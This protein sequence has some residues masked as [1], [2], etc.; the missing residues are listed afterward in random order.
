MSTTNF[1]KCDN[2]GAMRDSND[3]FCGNCGKPFRISSSG[4]S[5]TTLPSKGPLSS[6]RTPTLN[7]TQSGYIPVPPTQP[8]YPPR[9]SSPL[10]RN[11]V[12]LTIIAVLVL[13]LI[14]AGFFIGMQIGKGNT[15]AVISTTPDNSHQAGT[16]L[17]N[18]KSTTV[19]V[20]AATP[21]TPLSPTLIPSPT[22]QV[23]PGTV[24]CQAD[25]STQWNGWNGTSDW[26]ILNGMLVNDGTTFHGAIV[27]PC[28]L[29]TMLWR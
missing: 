10:Q 7:T 24:L 2:C 19:T 21:T 16:A 29:Q 1:K 13:L 14:G 8:G 28:Q 15:S 20:A 3:A 4:H 6:H 26:K 23:G 17:T 18:N 25:A 22:T 11:K 5:Y 12:Y 9:S 27:A